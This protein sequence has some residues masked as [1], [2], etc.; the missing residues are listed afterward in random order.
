[1]EFKTSDVV[2]L[3]SGGPKMTVQRIIGETTHNS[4]YK[5]QDAIMKISGYENGDVICQWFGEHNKLET[6]VFKPTMLI[7]A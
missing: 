1:M 6:G 5:S 3:A 2:Q 4:L 7:K